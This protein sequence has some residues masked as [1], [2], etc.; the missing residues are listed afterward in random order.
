LTQPAKNNNLR[1]M[2]RLLPLTFFL[3]AAMVFTGCE[4]T[5]DR[6]VIVNK[7]YDL[8]GAAPTRPAAIPAT[9]PAPASPAQNAAAGSAS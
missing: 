4:D 3:C 8:F 9:V 5:N 7:P 2:K 6:G 1:N